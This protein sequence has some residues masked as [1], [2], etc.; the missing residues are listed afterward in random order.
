[1][2]RDDLFSTNASILK[3]ISEVSAQVC[4]KAML[5]II[6]NPVNSLVPIASEVYKKA[7]VYDPKRIFGVSSLDV[8]RSQ[9]FIG[10]GKGLDPQKVDV[11]VIGGHSGITILPLIS[12]AKPAVSYPEDELKKLTSRIQEAGT[13][14]SKSSIVLI[15]YRLLYRLFR[16]AGS[17]S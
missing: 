8:V 6:T 10:E 7:G 14:V 17:Q 5:C 9:T 12:R 3:D 4:P 11:P 16:C 2:T 1:M 15:N 13:E